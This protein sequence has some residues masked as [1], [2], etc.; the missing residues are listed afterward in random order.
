MQGQNVLREYLFDREKEVV[1]IM[2]METVKCKTMRFFC[3]QKEEHER[4]Y[5][6]QHHRA[7]NALFTK[8]D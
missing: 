4:Q 8:K 1:T 3:A 7:I 6:N 2:C 5:S